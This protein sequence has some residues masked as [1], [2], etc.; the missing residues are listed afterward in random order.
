MI[1]GLEHLSYEERLR[2]LGMFRLKKR[3]LRGISSVCMGK[4][5]IGGVRLRGQWL[6]DHNPL[7]CCRSRVQ[8]SILEPVHLNIFT[9]DLEEVVESALIKF[10]YSIELGGGISQ[11]VQ[12][13]RC[14]SE[15]LSEAGGMG[16]K[17]KFSKGK[18]K[19][20]CLGRNSRIVR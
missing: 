12:G 6:M 15:A 17:D 9:D 8:G 4:K 5:Q 16:Q 2:E 10:A 1:K 18:C 14:H 13:L 11:Y 7:G 3:W 20:L 19:V